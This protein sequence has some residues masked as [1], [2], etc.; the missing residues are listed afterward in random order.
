V[1]LAMLAQLF[2][3]AALASTAKTTNH[4]IVHVIVDEGGA[5][6]PALHESMVGYLPVF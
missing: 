3:L 4:N 1:A 5:L 6:Q 2:L